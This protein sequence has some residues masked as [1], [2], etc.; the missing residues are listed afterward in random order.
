MDSIYYILVL[1][2]DKVF[3]QISLFTPYVICCSTSVSVQFSLLIFDKVIWR[4]ISKSFWAQF[5][6]YA[7]QLP[8]PF[9]SR[10]YLQDI[11]FIPTWVQRFGFVTCVVSCQRIGG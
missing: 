1:I 11:V 4:K 2:Y 8:V 6:P 9:Q 7:A 3:S 5:T 10:S